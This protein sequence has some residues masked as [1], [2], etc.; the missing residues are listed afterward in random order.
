MNSELLSVIAF[1]GMVVM[2]VA[3][4][5]MYWKKGGREAEKDL[6]TTTQEVIA[7]YKEQVNQLKEQVNQY[8]E[9]MHKLTIEI[10]RLTGVIEEKDKNNRELKD[11]LLGRNPEMD[12]FFK[13]AAPSL[14]KVEEFMGEIS[15]YMKITIDQ[16]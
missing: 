15:S 5:V 16:K 8:R 6:N 12:N 11:L 3:F 2:T 9:D 14:K 4:F 10:G 7:T 1:A 13:T